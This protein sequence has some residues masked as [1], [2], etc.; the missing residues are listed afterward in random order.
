MRSWLYNGVSGATP[1]PMKPWRVRRAELI[2]EAE[3]RQL[4]KRHSRWW[5]TSK[6]ERDRNKDIDRLIAEGVLVSRRAFRGSR[7]N[8][9]T[10]ELVTPLP[11]A[12]EPVQRIPYAKR[13]AG[14]AEFKEANQ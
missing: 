14:I 6:I 5:K 3:A 12:P 10:I 1:T 8:Y 9:T 13:K 7:M 4:R 2:A 11:E